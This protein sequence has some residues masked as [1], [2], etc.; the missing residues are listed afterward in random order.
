LPRRDAA[1][2]QVSKASTRRPETAA[3]V[4]SGSTVNSRGAG[5]PSSLAN[6]ASACRSEMSLDPES[7]RSTSSAVWKSRG[8]RAWAIVIDRARSAPP[9]DVS[10][11]A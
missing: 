4:P 9:L 10:P 11:A 2:T 5:S 3:S 7:S 1:A 8:E 6:S